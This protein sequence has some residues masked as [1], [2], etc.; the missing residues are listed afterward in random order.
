NEPWGVSWEVWR[1]GGTVAERNKNVPEGKLEY[2]TPG[3]QKLVD[4]CRAQGARNLIVAG[5]LDWAYDLTGVD[6]G[7]AL[8]DTKG[9]GVV[10]DTHMYSQKK[11]YYHNGKKDFEWDRVVLSGGGKYPVIIGEFGNGTEKENFEGAVLEFA[12]GHDL[13]WIAWSLHPG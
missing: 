1:N 9:R 11:A 13:P 7:Y 12:A 2:H 3:L 5:G 8:K 10:Y 6:R 4:V